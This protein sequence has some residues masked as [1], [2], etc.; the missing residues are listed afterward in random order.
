MVAQVAGA[1]DISRPRV[2][3]LSAA[4]FASKF[5]RAASMAA[6]LAASLTECILV[7][8]SELLTTATAAMLPFG[9]DAKA[10]RGTDSSFMLLRVV[11]SGS[12]I[13]IGMLLR[14]DERLL[15][16]SECTLS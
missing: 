5:L 7:I 1:E 4:I 14:T 2:C 6:S 13:E 8:D 15:L 10:G 9:G 11:K 16:V 12:E 3:E